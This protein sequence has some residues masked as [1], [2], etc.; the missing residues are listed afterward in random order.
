MMQYHELN[1]F[2]DMS[3]FERITTVFKLMWHHLDTG[4]IPYCLLVGGVVF[5]SLAFTFARGKTLIFSL[6][7]I[8]VFEVLGL[9][10]YSLFISYSS[11]GVGYYE[12]EIEPYKVENV[13]NI[14]KSYKNDIII[15]DANNKNIKLT[16]NGKKINNNDRI[17]VRT[18][19]EIVNKNDPRKV[20]FEEYD[21][22]DYT[23]LYN[24]KTLKA[25]NTKSIWDVL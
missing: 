25:I 13:E 1:K 18:N 16:N 11:M 7:M 24:D 4:A 22:F 14:D 15:K 12:T 21:Y 10:L 5:V 17:T 23:Y 6:L 19:N 20:K 2:D 9:A 3:W 8:V